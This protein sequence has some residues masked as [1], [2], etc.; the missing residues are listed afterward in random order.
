MSG[1]LGLKI[2][3]TLTKHLCIMINAKND[4]KRGPTIWMMSKLREVEQH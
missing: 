3:E 4:K 1:S 2:G